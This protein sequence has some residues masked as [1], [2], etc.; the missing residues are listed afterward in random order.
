M[1]D[2]ID[3]GAEVF[4]A[5]EVGVF[6]T[7]GNGMITNI[8]RYFEKVTTIQREELIGRNVQYVLEKDYISKSVCQEVIKTRKP[9]TTILKY[10]HMDREVIV[11]GMP[12]CDEHKTLKFVVCTMRDW[13]LL[14]ELYKELETVKSQS[15]HYKEQ[16]QDLSLQQLEIEDYI[17][18]D[19][20]TK[21]L[22]QMAMKVASVDSTVLILGESGVGKD[23]LAKFIHKHSSRF[24]KG[25]FIH[26]NCGA[27]PETLFESEFFGY[28]PG[29]FTGANKLGKPGLLEMADN[30]TL[31]LDEIAE[32]PL[33]MQA[34][35]LKVLQEKTIIRVGDTREKKIDIKVIAAT[36]KNLENLVEKHQFREDLYYR[37]NVF[38]L[39]I[40][41]LRQRRTDIA[42]LISYFLNKF[43]EKFHQTKTMEQE[44]VEA[45][46]NYEWPGNIRELEHA[47]ERLV[48]LSPE[49][50]IG[51]RHL[52]ETFSKK[53]LI[54]E[55]VRMSDKLP[56]KTIIDE[57]EKAIILHRIE[58]TNVL[59]DAARELGIDIST[60]TRKKQKYGIFKK[61]ASLHN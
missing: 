37:L 5:L 32:I 1:G 50:V 57:V 23:R 17:A 21:T 24:E 42:P 18:K 39:N 6:I 30:G 19:P 9:I 55:A 10:K 46:I 2:L 22:L 14:T 58:K 8:N 20:A 3:F 15:E 60:L 45:L 34:K 25:D 27:I 7:D 13:T 26:V 4:D 48:V 33:F 59:Q 29:A 43:N 44:A 51:I 53:L 54:T 61:D 11:T 41:S 47:I 52:P 36:N 16:L 31:F 38:Q 28:S 12:V 40:P 49:S 35:L 56:L